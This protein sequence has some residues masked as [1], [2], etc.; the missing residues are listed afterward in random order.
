MVE[1][2]A[3]VDTASNNKTPYLW[4]LILDIVKKYQHTFY[5]NLLTVVLLFG[6]FSFSGNHSTTPSVNRATQTELVFS[7]SSKFGEAI[8]YQAISGDFSTPSLRNFASSLVV[9]QL[10]LEHSRIAKTKLEVIRQSAFTP[11][12]IRIAMLIHQVNLSTGEAD[13]A[14]HS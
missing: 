3:F 6:V 4:Y 11:H 10:S 12:H 14:D 8:F 7:T 5:Q 1:F 9:Q 13:V 2:P